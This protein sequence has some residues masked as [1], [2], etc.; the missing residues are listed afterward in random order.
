M[1]LQ[2][3]EVAVANHE[4]LVNLL[5]ANNQ[6]MNSASYAIN[7]EAHILQAHADTI[8]EALSEIRAQRE[9]R[10]TT[11]PYVL[12]YGDSICMG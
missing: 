7:S 8:Q 5:G 1:E 9:L 11:V 4:Q 10:T 6:L 2:R 3:E 12:T